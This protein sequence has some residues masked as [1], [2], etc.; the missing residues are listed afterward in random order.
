M[1]SGNG[2]SLED[3]A[4]LLSLEVPP[5]VNPPADAGSWVWF[6]PHLVAEVEYLELTPKCA[7]GTRFPAF[8]L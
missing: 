1:G 3:A 6:K 4:G 8:P 7:S 2:S 5:V